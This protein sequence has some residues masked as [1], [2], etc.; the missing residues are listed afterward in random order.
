VQRDDDTAE[1][2][3]KRLEVYHNLTELLLGY[4]GKWAESGQSG[5]PKFVRISGV[6]PVEEVRDNAFAALQK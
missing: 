2:V 6:G 1:T 3:K 4:Y 5:A